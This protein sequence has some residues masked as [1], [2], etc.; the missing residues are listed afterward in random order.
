MNP[1]HA[2]AIRAG[3]LAARQHVRPVMFASD[4]MAAAYW[5]E[6]DR[7]ERVRA[8]AWREIVK[9]WRNPTHG[10]LTGAE[11]FTHPTTPTAADKAAKPSPHTQKEQ[12]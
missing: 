8:K 11:T 1:R 3:I 5:R 10:D 6:R 4:L 2:R 9:G 12:Q 7:L